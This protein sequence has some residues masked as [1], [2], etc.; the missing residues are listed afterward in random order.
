[1]KIQLIDLNLLEPR[2]K[3]P[4]R[5]D[6]TQYALLVQAIRRVGFL[7][8][9]LVRPLPPRTPRSGVVA[10]AWEIVDGVHRWRAAKDAE[11]AAVECVVVDSDD[12]EA[13]AL[14]IG[15]NRMRGELDLRAVAI[16]LGELSVEGWT[17]IEM[18]LTGFDVGEIGDLI[19]TLDTGTPDDLPK[20]GVAGPDDEDKG[21][22]PE[23]H[24]LEVLFSSKKDMQTC[25]RKLKKLGKGDLALGLLAVLTEAE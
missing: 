19:K 11:L 5:M 9:L 22:S 8:P 10:A 15:M 16:T 12:A 13:S 21:A 25:K 1:M 7:Q 3:N 20:G 23:T 24:A 4:N 18:A 14:Q 17:P 2:D 6:E